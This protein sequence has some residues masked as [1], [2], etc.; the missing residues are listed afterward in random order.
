LE[1][2]TTKTPVTQVGSVF[3]VRVFNPIDYSVIVEFGRLPGGK[4]PPLIPLVGWAVRHGIINSLPV[5]VT[6]DMFPKQWAASAA[7]L[8]NM[9]GGG[10]KGG[11]K[12]KPLDPIVLDLLTVRLI[13]KKIVDQGIAGRH[14]FTV[15]WERKVTTFKPD[16]A[17][18]LQ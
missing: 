10:S 8:R 17:A 18:M 1:A 4:T 6:F 2:A 3:T 15:A 13:A 16:I 5:N 14:P 11:G 7:I 12:Q 9:G